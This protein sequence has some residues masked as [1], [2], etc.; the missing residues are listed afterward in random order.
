MR[1]DVY[2]VS[3]VEDVNKKYFGSNPTPTPKPKAD[4]SA[5]VINKKM[6]PVL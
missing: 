2:S 1:I 6:V 4:M 3:S 5:R